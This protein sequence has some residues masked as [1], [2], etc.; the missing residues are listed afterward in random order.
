MIKRFYGLTLL[1]V[2]V[3][4]MG[5][6]TQFTEANIDSLRIGM[7]SSEI[8]EMFGSP[9]QVRSSVCGSATTKGAWICETWTYESFSGTNKFTFS[10]KPD[11]KTLNDWT[12]KK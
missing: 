3:N 5:C 7:P 12:V 1:F 4:L 8:K 6:A 2:T 9:T 10:V 11:G